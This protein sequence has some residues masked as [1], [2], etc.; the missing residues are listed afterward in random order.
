MLA[1]KEEVVGISMRRCG[2][3]MKTPRHLGC[4]SKNG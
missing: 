4:L 2:E 1:P 3:M